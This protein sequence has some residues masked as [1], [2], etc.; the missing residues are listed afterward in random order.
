MPLQ[1]KLI[2]ITIAFAF[3]WNVAIGDGPDARQHKLT[4][5]KLAPPLKADRWFKRQPLSAYDAKKFYVVEVWATWCGP[6]ILQMPHLSELAKKYAQ[7]GLEVIALT[8]T[9]RAN[10]VEAVEKFVNGRGKDFQFGY[11]TCCEATYES[12]MAASGN[13]AIPCSFVIDRQGKI[14]YIGRPANLDYVLSRVAAGKWRGKADADELQ[15]IADSIKALPALAQEDAKAAMKFINKL[16]TINLERTYSLDVASVKVSTLT[17]LGKYAEAKAAIETVKPHY[18]KS[19]DWGRLAMVASGLASRMN[20]P[21][22]VQ[23]AYALRVM[24]ESRTAAKEDVESL[25]KIAIA[26]RI[27][28]DLDLFVECMTFAIEKTDN[29]AFKAMLQQSIDATKKQVGEQPEK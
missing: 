5:G 1:L 17:R 16:E 18:L 6:C 11:A 26:Y 10:T 2:A 4:V 12:F 3:C 20:N 29:S 22:G 9:D 13:D 28:N 7:D 25:V 27:S 14:A 24:K 21:E 15:N 8:A 19:Q 23:R